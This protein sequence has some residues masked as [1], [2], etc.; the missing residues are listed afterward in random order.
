[1]GFGYLFLG[2]LISVNFVYEALTLLPALGLMYV[3]LRRLSLYNRPLREA[4]I[5]LYPS[6]AVAGGS[7]AIELLRMAGAISEATQTAIAGILSPLTALLLLLFHERLLTGIGLLAEETALPKLLVR[8]R[9]NRVFSILVFGILALLYLPIKT[10]WFYT[11]SASAFLP[12]LIA[13]FVT[14]VL[15]AM[16]IYSAYMWISTPEDVDMKRKKTGIDWL[17][18][19]NEERDRREEEKTEKKKKELAEIYRASEQKYREKQKN[20]RTKK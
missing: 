16:L 6:L 13:R 14:G 20:K 10:D 1:M 18:R 8:A 12:V 9:R 17:D 11:L 3:G 19:M 2:Y 4:L 7:F 15:N 5:W